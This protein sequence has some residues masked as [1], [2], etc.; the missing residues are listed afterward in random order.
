VCHAKAGA[1]AAGDVADSHHSPWGRR[2][3]NGSAMAKAE[4]RSI[5]RTCGAT[6]GPRARGSDSCLAVRGHGSA[7]LTRAWRTSFPRRSRPAFLLPRASTVGRAACPGLIRAI[8]LWD[9]ALWRD[10]ARI[11]T[12]SDVLMPC[13]VRSHSAPL[14]S[15]GAM[16]KPR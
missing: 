15:T 2:T 8:F 4:I 5:Q 16:K 12:Q 1:P 3:R 11:D 9:T 14:F 13:I 10:A 6:T 7:S